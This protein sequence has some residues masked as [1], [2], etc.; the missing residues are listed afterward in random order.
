MRLGRLK[1]PVRPG[2]PPFIQTSPSTKAPK[3]HRPGPLPGKRNAA[4]DAHD[5]RAGHECLCAA[6]HTEL[7]AAVEAIRAE[8]A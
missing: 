8:I 1:D 5:T 2:Q 7:T 3:R 4:Y 6:S